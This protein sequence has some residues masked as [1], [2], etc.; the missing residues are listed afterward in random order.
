MIALL[1]KSNSVDQ[2]NKKEIGGTCTKGRKEKCRGFSGETCK[3]ETMWK[4]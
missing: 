1:D 3:K 2:I 4:I